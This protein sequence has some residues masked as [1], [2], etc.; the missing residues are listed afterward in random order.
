MRIPVQRLMNGTKRYN[1][2]FHGVDMPILYAICVLGMILFGFE[3]I[4]KFEIEHL[5]ALLLLGLV[6]GSSRSHRGTSRRVTPVQVYTPVVGP[7]VVSSQVVP[8]QIVTPQLVAPQ[9]LAT[10]TANL[11]VAE[12]PSVYTNRYR[13]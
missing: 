12:Q 10:P 5:L 7:Q 8:S 13:G 11:L 1:V 3:G 9:V 2:L 4:E 6:A